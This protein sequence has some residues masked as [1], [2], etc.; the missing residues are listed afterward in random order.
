M[1]RGTGTATETVHLRLVEL[2]SR[3]GWTAMEE[4]RIADES[5]L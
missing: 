4:G 2:D 5:I 3:R 1:G